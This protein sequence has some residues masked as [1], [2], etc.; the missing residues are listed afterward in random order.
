[1]VIGVFFIINIIIFNFNI[2]SYE[3]FFIFLIYVFCF[4]FLFKR[5]KNKINILMN[6]MSIFLRFCVYFTDIIWI[7][8][9]EDFF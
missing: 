7:R 1:M 9:F 5:K 4:V 8:D 2:V 6:V 3:M